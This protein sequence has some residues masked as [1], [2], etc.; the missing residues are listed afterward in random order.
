MRT[1]KIN[2]KVSVYRITFKT[3]V[4]KL[5]SLGSPP[6][7]AAAHIPSTRLRGLVAVT[8]TWVVVELAAV[9]IEF[10]TS[11]AITNGGEMKLM[12]RKK[13]H[14]YWWIIILRNY[15]MVSSKCTSFY[16]CL[17]DQI[18]ST[19]CCSVALTGEMYAYSGPLDGRL[20][21]EAEL[22]ERLISKTKENVT[23]GRRSAEGVKQVR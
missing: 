18:H 12:T 8:V 6:R 15:S 9:K 4:I 23:E 19:V 20:V 3:R 2:A 13:R 16:Q 1:Q 14:V 11:S 5:G 17:Q 7:G 21:A 10:R 22:K